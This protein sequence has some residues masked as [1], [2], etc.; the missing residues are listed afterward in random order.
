[1]SK[2]SDCPLAECQKRFSEIESRLEYTIDE[3]GW[4]ELIKTLSGLE[5]RMAV[6]EKLLERQAAE[7]ESLKKCIYGNGSGLAIRLQTLWIV[8][9]ILCA[10]VLGQGTSA[11]IKLIG[12]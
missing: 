6:V 2:M 11:I 12:G 10:L 1:M 7:L 8:V 4:N 9:L 3:K 5:T